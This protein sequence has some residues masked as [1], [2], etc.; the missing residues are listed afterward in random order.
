MV[1]PQKMLEDVKKIQRQPGNDEKKILNDIKNKNNKPKKLFKNEI[2]V[3][4]VAVGGDTDRGDPPWSV[5][6]P[7]TF[8]TIVKSCESFLNSF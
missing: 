3:Y 8:F 1:I 7:T 4:H 2:F 6:P 5:S